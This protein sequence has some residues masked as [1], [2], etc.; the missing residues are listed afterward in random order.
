MEKY[1]SCDAIGYL[2]KLPCIGAWS[3]IKLTEHVV[4]QKYMKMGILMNV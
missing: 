4:R 1:F 2:F 3:L